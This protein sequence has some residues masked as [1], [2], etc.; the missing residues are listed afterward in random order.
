MSQA[1]STYVK[2]SCLH[3]LLEQKHYVTLFAGDKYFATDSQGDNN[4]K[5]CMMLSFFIDFT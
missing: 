3:G 5:S 1:S 2:Y 4:T